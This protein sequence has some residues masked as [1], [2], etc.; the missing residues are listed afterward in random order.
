MPPETAAGTAPTT[1]APTTDAAATV[2]AAPI[3]ED[4]TAIRRLLSRQAHL[5]DT[6]QLDEWIQGYVEDAV[7]TAHGTVARG[8]AEIRAIADAQREAFWS[9]WRGSHFLSEPGIDVD[10]VAGTA[11]GTTH[12]T[13]LG[14]GPDGGYQVYVVGR[15]H[16]SFV[17]TADGRWLLTAREVRT[18]GEEAELLPAAGPAS[19]ATPGATGTTGTT[20]T[21]EP[22]ASAA[23]DAAS[24]ASDASDAGA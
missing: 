18:V 9:D 20:G 3:A 19:D 14:L 23:S 5:R 8:R 10:P 13:F 7:F 16:D 4:V 6:D 12:Y 11:T 21:A 15:Y 2:A 17:R 24:D 22:G 1:A